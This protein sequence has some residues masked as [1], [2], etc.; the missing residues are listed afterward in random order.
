MKMTSNCD[1]T[2]TA[3]HKQTTTICHWMK[4]PWKFSAYATGSS[5]LHIHGQ[6]RGVLNYC[7]GRNEL[8]WRPG[9]EASLAPLCSN[10]RAFGS[11]CTVLKKV[12]M[13][14]LGLFGAPQSFGAL[15]V[16]RRQ[17]NCAL[18]PPSLR[19][20]F[21]HAATRLNKSWCT[22]LTG[23]IREPWALSRAKFSILPNFLRH[24]EEK[25]IGEFCCRVMVLFQKLAQKYWKVFPEFFKYFPNLPP[26]LTPIALTQK[27]WQNTSYLQ[28][29]GLNNWFY[30]VITIFAQHVNMCSP[31]LVE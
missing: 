11:K 26:F 10:L 20:W 6:S 3:H 21:L 2:K 4:P 30:V 15:I 31:K 8:R 9:Q 27:L 19:P 7:Q 18:C 16:V 29:S 1:V 5:S 28:L 14:L 24:F 17:G 12:L 25:W 13:T 22:A 23:G